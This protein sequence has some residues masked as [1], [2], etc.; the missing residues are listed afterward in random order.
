MVTRTMDL[1]VT[2]S[3]NMIYVSGKNGDCE[4]SWTQLQRA[5]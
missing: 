5:E 2:I 1:S 3:D 4:V